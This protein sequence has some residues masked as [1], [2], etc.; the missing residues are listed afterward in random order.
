MFLLP[1]SLFDFVYAPGTFQNKANRPGRYEFY[2]MHGLNTSLLQLMETII[3][4]GDPA[5]LDLS[6][7]HFLGYTGATGN[8]Q[9]CS[10]G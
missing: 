7:L 9:C 5:A 2:L 6:S 10:N 1:I 4:S 3:R 8:I